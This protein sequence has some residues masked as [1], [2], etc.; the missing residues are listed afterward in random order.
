M[1]VAGSSL[2]T[3][4]ISEQRA[5]GHVLFR[6]GRRAGS[7]VAEFLGLGTLLASRDGSSWSFDPS[8]DADPADIEKVRAGLA[9]ALLRHLA[10]KVTFHGAA[11]AW[12]GSAVAFIGESG[13]G[14][15]TLAA[16]L[17]ADY[18]GALVA[19]D[20]AAIELEPD[21]VEL[22]PTEQLHWLIGSDTDVKSAVAPRACV[23]GR[24]RLRALCRL[25]FDDSASEVTLRRVRGLPSLELMIGSII[26]FVVDEPAAQERELEQ[27]SVLA[28]VVPIYELRRPRSMRL[29]AASCSA[30]RGLATAVELAP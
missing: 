14:M 7:P 22:A 30:L 16:A 13:A 8:P 6:V 23:S 10:G 29:L 24:T 15:W 9:P 27:L 25:V 18:G 17:C 2:A 21:R 3:T 5:D 1:A 19:D 26:R 12:T 20:T 28:R 4:W 11:V